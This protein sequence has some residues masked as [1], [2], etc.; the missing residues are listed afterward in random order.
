MSL[1][2]TCP[3]LWKKH[4]GTPTSTIT[5][6]PPLLDKYDSPEMLDKETANLMQVV[7]ALAHLEQKG[8]Q[9]GQLTCSQI[10]LHPSGKVKLRRS[11]L[12]PVRNAGLMYTIR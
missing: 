12:S 11:A 6:S 5:V 4:W 3:V 8:L 2:S 9:H 1:T 10:L 7:A